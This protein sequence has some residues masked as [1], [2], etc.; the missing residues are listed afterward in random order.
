MTC[1]VLTPEVTTHHLRSPP[2]TVLPSPWGAPL[3]CSCCHRSCAAPW[4]ATCGVILPQ[5]NTFRWCTCRFSVS[6][7]YQKQLAVW[8]YPSCGEEL[9]AVEKALLNPHFR[10]GRLNAGFCIGEAH[11]AHGLTY[12]MNRARI[13][14]LMWNTAAKSSKQTA[15]KH[16]ANTTIFSCN[17]Q[18][19][20]DLF[21]DH[22]GLQLTL[23]AHFG[24]LLLCSKEH[25]EGPE[26][27]K[28]QPHDSGYQQAEKEKKQ[29]WTWW[30]WWTQISRNT[31]FLSMKSM[32]SHQIWCLMISFYQL[33]YLQHSP[34]YLSHAS[35]TS[36]SPGL[37]W[38]PLLVVFRLPNSLKL[39]A[40]LRKCSPL[41]AAGESWPTLS[42]W[43]TNAP[44]KPHL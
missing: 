20:V 7:Q 30:T 25:G 2:P 28:I 40:G 33:V 44:M 1:L 37:F 35:K 3:L 10:P 26:L 5:K 39:W 41:K 22:P 21:P 4:F 6:I 36:A 29:W 27:T 42:G 9:V 16:Q 24:T 14:L 11:I 23:V 34:C 15:R 12:S 43:P 13:S 19:G 32:K 8:P 31:E 38:Q 18:Q 17:K